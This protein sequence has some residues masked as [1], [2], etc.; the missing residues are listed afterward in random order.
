MKLNDFL[1]SEN[2]TMGEF[3][4]VVGATTATISRIAD[5][6]VVPRKA[7]MERIYAATRGLVTPHDLVGIYCAHACPNVCARDS[8]VRT[9]ELIIINE[10]ALEEPK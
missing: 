5:G 9:Q 1:T 2:S 4:K 10:T 8:T 7:L 3:A 6:A